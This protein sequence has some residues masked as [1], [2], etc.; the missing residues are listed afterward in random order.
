MKVRGPLLFVDYLW[1]IAPRGE[2]T[3]L[4]STIL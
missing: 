4:Q 1:A 2:L 3:Y